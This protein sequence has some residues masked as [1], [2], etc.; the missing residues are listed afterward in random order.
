MD[1]TPLRPTFLERLDGYSRPE[2]GQQY[3]LAD[4][5]LKL[6]LSL[7][8]DFEPSFTQTGKPSL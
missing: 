5:G 3:S 7:P 6:H 4:H 1:A 8:Q 2:T